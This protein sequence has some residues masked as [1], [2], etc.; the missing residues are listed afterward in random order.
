MVSPNCS[1][2]RRRDNQAAKTDITRE[3]AQEADLAHRDERIE[4]I[5]RVYPGAEVF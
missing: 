4:V 5:G 1:L 3:L 2:E